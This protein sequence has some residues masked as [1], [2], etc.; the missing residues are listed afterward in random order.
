MIAGKIGTVNPANLFITWLQ[1]GVRHRQYRP[2]HMTDAIGQKSHKAHR[3]FVNFVPALADRCVNHT[4]GDCRDFPF[5]ILSD[6]VYCSLVSFAAEK[7]GKCSKSARPENP[8]IA[9]LNPLRRS[10]RQ[11]EKSFAFMEFIGDSQG[12]HDII[13]ALNNPKG[14]ALCLA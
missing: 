7:P 6:V 1:H 14:D 4:S 13:R 8:T 10:V 9:E 3:F 12:Y 11:G 2:I 5:R